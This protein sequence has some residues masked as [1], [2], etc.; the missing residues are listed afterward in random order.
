MDTYIASGWYLHGRAESQELDTGYVIQLTQDP[1]TALQYAGDHGSVWAVM[2]KD[3]AKVLRLE[4]EW[5]SD[6]QLVVDAALVDLD[7]GR[8]PFAEDL[9]SAI[10]DG[11]DAGDL[12]R[13]M[14]APPK[15]VS[16]AGAFDNSEYVHWLTDRF[17][18][19]FVY[20]P[21]GAVAINLEMVDTQK[22]R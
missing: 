18:V 21:D 1:D 22:I 14:F 17:G 9:Y 6:M 19:D 13:S 7:K 10:D 16:D 4:G 5:V 20:T 8:L 11:E 3:A 15:I 12:I 2:P